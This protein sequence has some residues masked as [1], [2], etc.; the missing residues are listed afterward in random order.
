[1]RRLA[2]IATIVVGAGC[3]LIPFDP[4]P[5]PEAGPG[6]V[7]DC[8]PPFVLEE[9]TTLGA[10][11][12]AQFEEAQAEAGIDLNRRG[13]VRITEA[14]V[15]W[16]EFAPPDVP[17]VV[18]EGQL[19]CVMWADGSGLSTLLHE[20]FGQPGIDVGA[21]VGVGESPVVFIGVAVVVVLV[22]VVSWFAFRREPRS[23]GP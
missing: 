15:R 6:L 4:T 5:D 10:L 11:G 1:M 23:G 2:M 18:P 17:A 21:V 20:P 22:V 12:L 14:T 3:S 16:E 7:T 8:A 13:T 9:E 19:L